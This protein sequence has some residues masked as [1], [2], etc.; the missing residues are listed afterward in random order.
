MSTYLW[1]NLSIIVFP[2]LASFERRVAYWRRSPAVGLAVLSGGAIFVAWDAFF[3]K[4][5]YWSFNPVHVLSVRLFF[6]PLEEILFFVTVPYS[7]F[8]VLECLDWFRKDAPVRVPKALSLSAAAAFLAGGFLF[9]GQGYTVVVLF[10]CAGCFLGDAFLPGSPLKSRNFLLMLLASFPL[11]LFFNHLLTSIPVVL[12]S[13]SAI[14]GLR[15][16][17]IPLEDFFYNFSMLAVYGFFYLRFRGIL[18]IGRKNASGP[19]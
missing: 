5:G 13:P 17:S 9:F 19:S 18:T 14:W 12:Y 3:S 10:V 8:F 16:L 7:M 6:L 2:L 1:I 4:A 15:I 11:F